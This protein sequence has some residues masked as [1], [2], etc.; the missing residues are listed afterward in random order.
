MPGKPTPTFHYH[1]NAHVLGANFSRPLMDSIDVLGA[2]SLPTNGGHGRATVENFRFQNFVSVKHGYSHVSGSPQEAEGKK[3]YTTLVTAVAEGLNI[4]DVVTADR[5]V[6]RFASS[7]TLDVATGKFD[8]AEPNFSL[9]GTRFENLQ[10]AG[11]KTDVE[12]DFDLFHRIPT[13]EAAIKEYKNSKEFKKIVEDPFESTESWP[14]PT[15]SGAILCSIVKCKKMTTQ[16]PGVDRKGHCFIIP[17]FGKLFLGE[18]LVEYGRRT[19]TMVRFE[20]GSPISASGTFV[21][22]SSNGSPIP[23]NK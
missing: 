10:I 18:I 14:D 4:L 6:A 17:K 13:F 11:C 21:Q 23:P 16:C 7:H 8:D 2:T 22:L 19:L 5:V 15:K 12:I 20:L 9:L 1:A 3:H